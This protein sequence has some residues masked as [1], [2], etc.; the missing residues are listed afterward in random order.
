MNRIFSLFCLTI[1]SVQFFYG[2][3]VQKKHIDGV[4][5][6]IGNNVI[7]H[8]DIEDQILQYQSQGVEN[9][10]DLEEMVVE[11]LFFQKILLHFATLDSV[12]VEVSEVDNA[13]NQRILF[14]EQQLGSQEKIENYFGTSMSELISELRPMVETQILIQKMQHEITK[15]VYV[16]PSEVSLFYHSFNPDSLPLIEAKFQV[17]QILKIPEAANLSIEETLSKLEELRNRIL[18]GADFSTMAIL[19]S[20]DPGSSRNGG[21]YYNVVKGKFVKEFEA[22]AFSLEVDELSEIFQTEYGYHIAQL[23]DRRGNELDIRHILMTPKISNKDLLSSKSFLDSL[24]SEILNENIS[25]L[26]AAK[27]HSSDKETRYNGGLLINPNTNNSFFS[28]DEMDPVLVNEI[29]LLSDG[30]ITEPIYIKLSSGKEAYRIIKLVQKKEEHFA[31]LEDDYPFLKNYCFQ[32]KQEKVI[33]AW[34][35]EKIRDVH[36]QTLVD[37]SEYQFYNDLMND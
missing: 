32:M 2:Q 34:L 25:F 27:N 11:E 36:I 18:K 19:Y 17:A 5:A 29:Q 4:F 35:K 28:V 24:R 9:S 31:N 26:S 33:K 3:D 37:M 7:F 8:S 1:L 13:V 12:Q 10:F 23:I 6:T 21:A 30:G 22:V 15:D 14:F 16:S 20:E